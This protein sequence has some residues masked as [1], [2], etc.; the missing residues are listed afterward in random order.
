MEDIR[1]PEDHQ[2]RPRPSVRDL[3]LAYGIP[4]WAAHRALTDCI[5]IADVFQ[6][7]DDLET[8]LK[9]GLEPRQL[10][11]AHVSYSDRQLAKQAGLAG[12]T[13]FRAPG[14]GD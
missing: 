3:A 6:R 10:M 14:R 4:V 5:Y 12:T 1:W 7:C 2:L 9:H 8:L 11:R 13:R